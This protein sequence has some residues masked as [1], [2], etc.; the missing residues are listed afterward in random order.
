ML[1][2]LQWLRELVSVDPAC[3]EPGHL[4]ERLSIAGFEVEGIEDLAARAAGVVVGHVV[5]RDRHPNA[6]KLSVCKVDVGDGEPLQIVCGAP[7]VRQGLHV[8]VALVGSTLPAVGLTIKPA[9][10]RGVAS[11]GMICSLR[12]LGLDDGS[13]GIA[14]LDKLLT[15]VP[16][17]GTAVGPLLGLDDQ[18]LELAITANR[19]DGLSMR[20]IARE[21][22]ALSGGSTSFPAAAAVVA[23]EPLAPAAPD[24]EAIEA[25]GLFS[26]TSLEGVR[27]GP[28]PDWLRQRL[29]RAGVRP[30]NNVVD[31]TNLVMLE[32][33]QPLHAFDRDRLGELTG[34]TPQPGSIG[35][36]QGRSGESFV[37]LD[38]QERTLSEEALVVTCADHPIA[39]AGVIGGLGEAVTEA[40]TAI[41]L[42]AAVFAPQAV[43]RSA[44]SVGLRTEACSRFE[45][46]VPR[47]ITLAAADRAVALLQELAAAQL[48]GR[49]LHQNEWAAQLPLGLRRDALHN[50]LGPI[51]EDGEERDLDDGRISV[52][53]EALGCVLEED[54]EGWQVRVPPERAMDLKREVDLIE[55]VARL[56]GYDRFA[57][58]LPDPLI[59]G[60]LEPAQQLERRLRRALCAAGLQ[61]V[62]SLSLVSA[63]TDRV[64]LANPLLADYGHLRDNLHQELL[65][66]ARRN[67]Q[68]SLPGFWGFEIGRVFPG[69]AASGEGRHAERTLLVGVIAGE[70]CS[71][72][73]R[74]SGKPTPP[75]YFQ[76][77]GVLQAGLEPLRLPME[78]RPLTD[79]PLLHP[80]RA[81]QLVV[82]GK[83]AGWFGQLHPTE[84]EA[85][86]LPSAT[87]VFQLELEPLLSAGTRR[88]RWQPAFRPFATVPAS[89]RDLALVVPIDT[90]AAALLTAIRKAG[91]PLLEQAELVDRYEGAQLEA[92]RCSQAFRL[93]YRDSARTLTDEEVET[94]HGRVREALE[95][96]FGAE[97]RR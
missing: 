89:E 92:G 70:R 65:Q 14:E 97:Q 47:E 23:A 95:R 21:V 9:E 40:T 27:V 41:W 68:A 63:A 82:E 49:W 11:S 17:L 67:L 34:A 83:S 94:A 54:A 60:G 44:R 16:P 56:V 37:A 61:E 50:L 76:A 45:K 5:Q 85:L 78:D 39:L 19:P 31:I 62:V 51:V 33:G 42:E 75:D 84:A 86:D 58:H 7:N 73:W 4:A 90:S 57:T 88:N 12:E 20:G 13:D 6:D 55:E 87:Y 43:R 71:E 22:A 46:G 29:E 80:G 59:P 77:R 1:V 2:S 93:R 66:A 36:R 48:K 3:L 91:K 8:P 72:R 30:I 26:L 64:P 25:G 74:S 24:R 15:S 53:L 38:G 79:A 52:T 35:L 81:A 10:L 96:Q 28:S 18:V 69:G 32:T